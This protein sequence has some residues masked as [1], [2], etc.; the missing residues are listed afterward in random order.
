MEKPPE[1]QVS[2]KEDNKNQSSPVG[3]MIEVRKK[4]TLLL[5]AHI[6]GMLVPTA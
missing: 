2:N 5:V 6:W 3:G 1:T 4:F